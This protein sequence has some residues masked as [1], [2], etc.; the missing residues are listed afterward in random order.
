MSGAQVAAGELLYDASDV[1]TV[2]LKDPELPYGPLSV[3]EIAYLAGIVDG[4]GTIGIY[5]QGPPGT[6]HY[7][8]KLIVTNSSF[9]LIRWVQTRIGGAVVFRPAAKVG[10]RDMWHVVVVQRR[11]AEVIRLCRPFLIV[12]TPQADLAARFIE[13]T[14]F[15]RARRVSDAEYETRRRYCEE[16]MRLNR[17]LRRRDLEAAADLGLELPEGP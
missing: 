3:E 12:K 11:A 10:W 15:A 14:V 16:M 8:L 13:D 9:P 2:E 4:E 1:A 6:R 7:D 17:P 5:K